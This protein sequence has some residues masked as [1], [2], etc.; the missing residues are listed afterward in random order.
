MQSR[1]QPLEDR[2]DWQPYCIRRCWYWRCC[3]WIRANSCCLVRRSWSSSPCVQELN[4]ILTYSNSNIIQMQAIEMTVL[5]RS[6]KKNRKTW[7]SILREQ[8]SECETHC[9]YVS[10]NNRTQPYGQSCGKTVT[11]KLSFLISKRYFNTVFNCSAQN[12]CIY[13][14][15]FDM[16]INF[17]LLQEYLNIAPIS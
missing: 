17:H 3:I 13:K 8:Y 6:V 10:Q 1:A 16:Y 7:R 2:W 15:V 11:L 4:I 5:H 9:T 12:T 14:T